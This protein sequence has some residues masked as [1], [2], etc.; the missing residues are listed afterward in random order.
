MTMVTDSQAAAK[1]SD[2]LDAPALLE[3]L[4]QMLLIRRIEERTMQS[5]QQAKIGGF[6]HI[7]V[8]QEATAVGSIG[9]LNDDDPIITAYRDYGH[10]LARGRRD[11]YADI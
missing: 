11:R 7:H 5:Y 9:A 4:R 2:A 6:C 3:L 1:P 8:G 10:A